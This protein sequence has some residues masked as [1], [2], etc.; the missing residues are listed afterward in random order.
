MATSI[1][2]NPATRSK[3]LNT[4]ELAVQQ[5]GVDK[6]QEERR[7]RIMTPLMKTRRIRTVRNL[8]KVKLATRKRLKNVLWYADIMQKLHCH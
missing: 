1:G 2:I 8:E 3:K 7:H 5:K 4:T 6:T